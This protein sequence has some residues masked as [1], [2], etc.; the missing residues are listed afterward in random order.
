[1]Y[2]QTPIPPHGEMHRK[3]REREKKL[4]FSQLCIRLLFRGRFK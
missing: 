4:I 2:M 3:N 1:M